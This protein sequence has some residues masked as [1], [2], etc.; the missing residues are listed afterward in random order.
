MLRKRILEFLG[1]EPV[2]HW[3]GTRV[4]RDNVNATATVMLALATIALSAIAVLQWQTLEKTDTTM[5][6]QQRAFLAP[7]GLET[8]DNFRTRTVG[9]TEI[10][11]V[12]ENVG[13]EPA[14]KTNEILF[15]ANL[16]LG[17]FR[18]RDAVYHLI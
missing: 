12:I 9:Y 2:I 7:R 11:T 3:L 18:N 10:S 13:R 4:N 1:L 17:D 8:P 16:P 14:T 5:R 15:T 6:L